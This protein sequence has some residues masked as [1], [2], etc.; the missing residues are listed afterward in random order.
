M[1]ALFGFSVIFFAA[2][3][4]AALGQPLSRVAG[5]WAGEYTCPQ[6]LTSMTLDVNETKAGG[7]TALATFYAKP[8]NPGV[9]SGCFTMTGRFNASTGKFVL[10]QRQWIQRPDEFWYMIDLDGRVDGQSYRGAVGFPIMP[11]A[12]TTFELRKVA[13]PPRPPGACGDALTS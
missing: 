1:R 3:S 8:Q 2:L 4:G 13:R 11:G 5:S 7:V 12:C 10:T 9:P 6:G